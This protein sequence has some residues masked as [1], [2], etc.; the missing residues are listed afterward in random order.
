MYNDFEIE[1]ISFY[2]YRNKKNNLQVYFSLGE[3]S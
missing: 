1:S 2:L 3:N